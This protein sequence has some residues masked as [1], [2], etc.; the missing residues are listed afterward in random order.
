MVDEARLCTRSRYPNQ[1]WCVSCRSPSCPSIT[2]GDARWRCVLLRFVLWSQAELGPHQA[3]VGS[4]CLAGPVQRNEQPALLSNSVNDRNKERA[5]CFAKDWVGIFRLFRRWN[6]YAVKS[7]DMWW[8]GPNL[9]N[10]EAFTRLMTWAK[11]TKCHVVYICNLYILRTR[12]GEGCCLIPTF[13]QTEKMVLVLV[14][15]FGQAKGINHCWLV[16]SPNKP[17]WMV[18]AI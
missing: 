8:H 14:P 3:G 9:S 6:I 18:A 4:T 1:A 15:I 12:L 13:T 7:I 16:L 11:S 2:V 17:Y 10:L 5:R